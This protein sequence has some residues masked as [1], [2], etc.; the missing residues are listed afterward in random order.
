[1]KK[2]LY[3]PNNHGTFGKEWGIHSWCD[4]CGEDVEKI[5]ITSLLKRIEL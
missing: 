1:M 3:N 2:I 4:E 5:K